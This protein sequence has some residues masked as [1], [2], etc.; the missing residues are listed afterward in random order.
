M[1]ETVKIVAEERELT[2]TAASRRLRHAGWIP[3]VI[4]MVSGKSRS[5]RLNRHEFELTLKH[6]GK[7]NLLAD[8]D[9]GS[10]K[11]TKTL[12]KEIQ[13]EPV[14]GSILHADFLEISM[15]RKMRVGIPIQLSGDPA[16]VTQEEGILEHMLRELDVECLPGDIVDAI[17]VDVSALKIGDA[18]FVRDIKVSDKLTVLASPDSIIASVIA[19]VEEKVEEAAPVAE[20]AA[21][22]AEPEV[23]GRKKEEGEAEEGEGAE[24]A[25]KEKGKE[26]EGKEKGKDA[27][28][29]KAKEAAKETKEPKA[30]DA[31][32]K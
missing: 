31:K 5:I 3:G 6:H 4:S 12:L 32:K 21:E 11:P 25:G 27:K 26:G 28:E 24:A 19:P 16:G 20:G 10:D 29:P 23:I 17:V 14:N 13:Y 8:I 7:D 30:K 1:A 9:V 2:G 15:T 22:G 18:L